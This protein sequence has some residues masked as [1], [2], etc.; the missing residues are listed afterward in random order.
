MKENSKLLS[1]NL[2]FS[3]ILY[4][5]KFQHEGQGSKLEVLSNVYVAKSMCYQKIMRPHKQPIKLQC[6][7]IS[8]FQPIG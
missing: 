7:T 8:I 6:S 1:W 2:A 5:L 4:D 3:I